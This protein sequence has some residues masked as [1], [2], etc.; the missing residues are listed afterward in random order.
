MYRTNILITQGAKMGG[1]VL[2]HDKEKRRRENETILNK[3]YRLYLIKRKN[4]SALFSIIETNY[5]AK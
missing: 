1:R 4:H 5:Q 2:K 3:G